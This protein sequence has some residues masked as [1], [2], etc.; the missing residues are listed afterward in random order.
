[1]CQLV[2]NKIWCAAFL[3]MQDFTD[4]LNKINALLL[5]SCDPTKKQDLWR[6]EQTFSVFPQIILWL[7]FT[8]KAGLN[9]MNLC[10][11]AA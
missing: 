1:M 7:V 3:I 10:D 4:S 6:R 9:H 8:S 11:L 5:K 2:L